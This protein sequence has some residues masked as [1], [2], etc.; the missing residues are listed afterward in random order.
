M[1]TLHIPIALPDR[2]FFAVDDRAPVPPLLDNLELNCAMPGGEPP[3]ALQVSGFETAED[4]RVF[5]P[6]LR[7][8]FLWA[9]IRMGH[10]MM[11][12]A[13]LPKENNKKIFDGNVPQVMRTDIGAKPMFA[14]TTVSDGTHLAVLSAHL[15]EALGFE[16][17]ALEPR[18]TIALELFA[19]NEFVGGSL[20]QFVTL[21]TVLEV[22]VDD[23]S[24]S[25]KR[26]RVISLV[27][28]LRAADNRPDA[29]L[30]GK[31]LDDLYGL[32]NDTLHH[33]GAI[34][35]ASL[36]AL[37]GIVKATL[38]TLISK[39]LTLTDLKRS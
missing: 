8:A 39:K 28:K 11:P 35:A 10:S 31:K 21:F 3:F 12:S 24:S 32:R 6:P 15:N 13:Q 36:A 34:D 18:V 5:L 33:G 29:K 38:R 22:L 19:K 16:L 7:L 27:K 30:I 4:A 9:S 37:G 26:S 1:Y 14:T 25:G 2:K 20:A 23:T 17:A